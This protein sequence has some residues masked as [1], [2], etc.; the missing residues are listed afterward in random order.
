M[1]NVGQ[2]EEWI[3]KV[4][5]RANAGHPNEDMRV[6]LKSGWKDPVHAARQLAGLCNAASGADV[7][8]VVG[9]AE[10]GEIGKRVVGAVENELASWL[11]AVQ[12]CFV[13][14]PAPAMIQHLAVA[15]GDLTVVGMVFDTSRA[16]FVLK[17][18]S[19][20]RRPSSEVVF[21][22][23]STTRNATHTDL[24]RML[25]PRVEMPSLY[26]LAA[27]VDLKACQPNLNPSGSFELA[28]QVLVVGTAAHIV[29]HLSSVVLTDAAGTRHVF[30]LPLQS[31]APAISVS[32]HATLDILHRSNFGPEAQPSL[33]VNAPLDLSLRLHVRGSALPAIESIPM[34]AVSGGIPSAM[35]IYDLPSPT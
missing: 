7:L 19:D 22:E 20:G 13:G 25:A 21:R 33:Q 31:R 30:P 26:F 2:L 29:T 27:S 18:T 9:V 32:G 5:E 12:S 35:W 3:L 6:E 23:G 16:P 4:V 17:C 8:W 28:A 10:K 14:S 11:P 1:M 34:R 24:V 15:V